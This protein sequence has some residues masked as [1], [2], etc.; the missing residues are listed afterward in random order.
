[1]TNKDKRLII[2][3][4]KVIKISKMPT[5]IMF[6]IMWIINAFYQQLETGD[7]ADYYAVYNGI[8][9]N[10]FELGY[11][12]VGVAAK[13]LG[14]NFFMFRLMLVTITLLLLRDSILKYSKEPNFI[15]MIYMIHP[16]LLQC[17]QIRNAFSISVVIYALRYLDENNRKPIKFIGMIIL[18]TLF[19]TS[20]ILYVVLIL[21]LYAS[22]KMI[23]KFSII[24]LPLLNIALYLYKN[25]L[26]IFVG[27]LLRSSKVT[28]YLSAGDER[29]M[30][31]SMFIYLILYITVLCVYYQSNERHSFDEVLTLSSI[32]VLTYIPLM[33][34]HY[35]YYRIYEYFF[36]VISISL[37]NELYR[38][39][40][41][42]TVY[43]S[44]VRVGFMAITIYQSYIW[45]LDNHNAVLMNNILLK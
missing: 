23:I 26:A 16:F 24:I 7:Y 5:N 22:P 35:D 41:L 29:F 43:R 6:C 28:Y 2:R 11:Y 40:G 1:M 13:A 3:I 19:H 12:Y 30:T 33:L 17:I 32:L 34:V 44:L 8:K 39:K 45:I 31:T 9:E 18:G 37:F 36:P 14:I 42:K 21:I 38:K 4:P 15:T 27:N 10:Y 25:Q 20:T